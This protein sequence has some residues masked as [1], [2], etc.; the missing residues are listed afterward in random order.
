MSANPTGSRLKFLRT[1]EIATEIADMA[2]RPDYSPYLNDSDS[3]TR[4]PYTKDDL[5]SILRL[6]VEDE[7][8]FCEIADETLG[9]GSPKQVEHLTRRQI[10]TFLLAACDPTHDHASS[11]PNQMIRD[12][13]KLVHETAECQFNEARKAR[14]RAEIPE[15]DYGR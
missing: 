14:E 4:K 7:R 1:P 9:D 11:N 6:L 3:S 8:E 2:G 12:D 10:I 5:A 15:L 13:L